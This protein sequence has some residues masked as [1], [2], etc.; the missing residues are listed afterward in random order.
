MTPLRFEADYGPVWHELEA[1]LDLIEGRKASGASRW[2]WLRGT[3]RPTAPDAA[4]VAA[5][6]RRSCE[7]L[8]LARARAYPIGL[9]DRLE[10]LTQRAHQ[11]IYRRQNYG[12]A[13]LAQLFL[14][15]LPQAVRAHRSYVLVAALVFALPT[16]AMGLLT[17][18]DPGFVLSLLSVQDVRNFAQM[19]GD[20]EAPL[21]A[22]RSSGDDWL[23]FGYYIMNNISV[24]FQCFAS[25]LFVG[26]GSLFYLAFNGLLGGAVAGYLT[27]RGHGEAFYSFV[28][29]H[30]AFELTAIVIAGAAGLRIGHALLAPGR[31]TRLQ[32]V[33]HAAAGTAVLLYGV[34]GLLVVAAAVE[35]FWSSARWVSPGVKYGAGAACWAL[36]IAYLGWQGRPSALPEAAHA[37]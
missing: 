17:W 28:V 33:Q 20:D 29:T 11:A 3:Q 31:R 15:D 35:A 34:V 23:M 19:Y 6:Y 9:T 22:M 30:A 13:A 27:A 5:L 18:R 4:R 24:G 12:L 26:V 21:R 14:A 10:T 32:A 7:H 8:A 36:V 25:G 37:R 16:L 2:A 1:A